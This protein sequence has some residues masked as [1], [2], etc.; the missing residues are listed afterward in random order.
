MAA[1]TQLGSHLLGESFGG[2]NHSRA[3]GKSTHLDEQIGQGCQGFLG[4]EQ[5]L[6]ELGGG[7]RGARTEIRNAGSEPPSA[8][9]PVRAALVEERRPAGAPTWPPPRAHSGTPQSEVLLRRTRAHGHRPRWQVHS[10]GTRWGHPTPAAPAQREG[11]RGPT[12]LGFP[13]AS[14]RPLPEPPPS[15][16]AH[17]DRIPLSSPC[18]LPASARTCPL[19][20]RPQSTLLNASPVRLSPPPVV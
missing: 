15:P 13:H 5:G 9:S 4:A 18:P 12:A 2:G 20:A 17:H 7:G 11:P 19:A 10:T 1:T 14:P 6:G 3:G 16:R 8:P